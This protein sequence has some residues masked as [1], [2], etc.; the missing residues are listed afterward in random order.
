[1]TVGEADPEAP[2]SLEA[3]SDLRRG[4]WWGGDLQAVRLGR[5]G[6]TALGLLSGVSL[7]G[8]F[9]GFSLGL[10]GPALGWPLIIGGDPALRACLPLLADG[11][12]V[13]TGRERLALEGWRDELPVQLELSIDL[14]PPPDPAS[15]QLVVQV[16]ALRSGRR[17]RFVVTPLGQERAS[18]P[19]L[20]GWRAARPEAARRA[21]DLAWRFRVQVA[22]G[23]EG[24]ELRG[25]AGHRLLGRDRVAALLH[26]AVALALACGLRP[27]AEVR[28]TGR[29][30]PAQEA[31]P[32]CRDALG[33][34]EVVACGACATR[35]HA[36]CLTEYGRCTVHGCGRPW[37][38]VAPRAQEPV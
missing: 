26:H 25:P 33:A 16:G 12:V 5:L 2:A 20:A 1:M 8:A 7:L 18:P 17:P 3:W 19:E 4:L 35:H 9:F 32:Y 23:P 37:T 13:R 34:L 11:R 6:P 22:W 21:A 30:G 14:D 38:R 24:V 28:I 36:A 15:D 31:C 10:V 29:E 27:A